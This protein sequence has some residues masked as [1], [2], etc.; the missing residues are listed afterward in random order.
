M[1]ILYLHSHDTGRY[2][3][4][5]GYA[6]DTPRLQQFAEEG[7]LF[8]QAFCA[9]PTCSPSRAAL[10]TGQY[11]HQNGMT[12]LAHKGGQLIDPSRM[13]PHV[14]RT[15]G[16]A[17]ALAGFQHVAPWNADMSTHG[18][19][20]DLLRESPP[21]RTMEEGNRW[22]AELATR[23]IQQADRG[24][25]FFLDCGFT[26][27]H[28]V[29]DGEQWH[30]AEAP[31]AGD[32]RYVRPP[33]PLP[34]TPETRR[35]FA[36]FRVA[37]GLLDT[38]MGTVLDALAEAGLADD[39]LVI[40]T[41]DHGIAYPHMKCNLTAHGT[42]VMLMLRGPGFHGGRVVDSL[43]SH[44][45]LF[46]TICEVAGLMPPEGLVG[47]SLTSPTRDAVFAEVNWHAAVEPMRVVRTARHA[48]I[49]RFMPQE[50]PV[51]PNCDDSVSKTLLRQAGWD[52]RPQESEVLYDLYFDPNEACNR[53]A[54]PAYAGVLAEMR[55]RL[56]AWMVD[57]GDPLLTGRLDPWPGATAC[58]VDGLSPQ[59]A[60]AP[61]A[62]IELDSTGHRAP[63]AK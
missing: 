43:V 47:V 35:D 38:C 42:G 52:D 45:D 51:L 31:P 24:R 23:Y 4:P 7:V 36:D 22:V 62:P 26:L 34:D 17:T 18:Y 44:V 60:W 27:T 9:A 25:P 13:L 48:Y 58:A 1:N 46:P 54:D 30:T 10:L 40:I 3:Q 19:D 21:P 12:A 33:A 50:H 28:R 49:R 59:G 55:D 63:A 11:P 8:R 56:Q 6:V 20:R 15:Q 16:Y 32:A 29:G 2:V 37:A 57:T 41:T 14:L 5:Y 61:A 53:A 39:T